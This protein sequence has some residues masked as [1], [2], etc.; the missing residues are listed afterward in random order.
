M[1]N[2][3]EEEEKEE[4]E[5]EEEE[6]LYDRIS[7]NR[8]SEVRLSSDQASTDDAGEPLETVAL[9]RAALFHTVPRLPCKNILKPLSSLCG[10]KLC[11]TNL[12]LPIDHR[13]PICKNGRIGQWR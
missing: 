6:D 13:V 3:E 9:E 11:G 10:T 8:C 5:K 1:V 7:I 2:E 12:V 4:E